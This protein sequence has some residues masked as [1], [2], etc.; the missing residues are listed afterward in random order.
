MNNECISRMR[1]SMRMNE[2]KDELAG[3]DVRAILES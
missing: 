1:Y 3:M 2:G